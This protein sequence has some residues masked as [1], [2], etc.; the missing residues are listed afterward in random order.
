MSFSRAVF[1]LL[2]LLVS[3]SPVYAIDSIL[4]VRPSGHH[5]EQIVSGISDELAGELRYEDI[6]FDAK[7]T[8]S[9]LYAVIERYQPRAI[10]LMGNRQLKLFRGLQEDRPAISLPPSIAV[11]ALFIDRVLAGSKNVTGILYEI[12]AVT[13]LVSLRSI[14]AKNIKRV[15]VLYR[16]DMID[17][18]EENRRYCESE[19]IE[20]V[21]VGI[22]DS[23]ANSTRKTKQALRKLADKSIDALWISN[24]SRLLTRDLITRSWMPF[25]TRFNKPVVVGVETLTKTQLNMGSLAVFPDHT[26]LGAQTAGKIFDLMDNRWKI[27]GETFEQP[28][29]VIKHVN[30]KISQDRGIRFKE[31]KLLQVDK[32]IR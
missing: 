8:K 4:I 5:F 3:S 21:S 14:T 29:S 32:V 31:S 20:L 12:P 2:L 30:V 7:S 13:S 11:A 16:H 19:G 18:I 28:L 1:F 22:S 24:D 10:V 27:E 23:D 15:G 26:G 25:M 9:D 17:M 6:V